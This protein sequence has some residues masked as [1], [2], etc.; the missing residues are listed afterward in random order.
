MDG[1][2]WVMCFMSRRWD[3]IQL[4][5]VKFDQA[6]LLCVPPIGTTR[7]SACVIVI[8]S[9]CPLCPLRRIHWI[10][11]WRGLSRGRARDWNG[12]WFVS[13]SPWS[14]ARNYCESLLTIIIYHRIVRENKR[15]ACPSDPSESL[16]IH[17]T[18]VMRLAW[19]KGSWQQKL[20][21]VIFIGLT[22]CTR[23]GINLLPG[24][25]L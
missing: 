13:L 19:L 21:I 3:E 17:G 15:E 22:L 4:I 24:S 7:S 2:C 1:S 20:T 16:A 5:R 25:V 18:M 6:T 23:E 12:S 8:L 9:P 11:C 10:L 14:S